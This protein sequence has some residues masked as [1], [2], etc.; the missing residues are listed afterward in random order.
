MNITEEMNITFSSKKE[1]YQRLKPALGAK[2]SEMRR[3]GFVYATVDDI[4]NYL[5]EVKWVN[6]KNLT[7]YEMTCDILNIDDSLID[8]YLRNKLNKKNRN[9]YF[10]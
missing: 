4:W 5:E 6:S 9:V 3:N 10:E 8:A 2:H 1:L 7:L